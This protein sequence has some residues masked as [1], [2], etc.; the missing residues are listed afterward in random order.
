VRATWRNAEELNVS[1]P[2]ALEALL[3]ELRRA[4]ASAAVPAA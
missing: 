4:L 3:V 2:L 1:A